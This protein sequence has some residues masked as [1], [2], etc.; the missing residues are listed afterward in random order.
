MI[1]VVVA[2]DE[3]LILLTIADHLIEEGF[4][5]LEARH[6]DEALAMLAH[7]PSIIHVLFTDVWM[8]GG[9]DGIMLTH[10]VKKHW[11][12]IGILV[13]SAHVAPL[14]EHL[15]VGCRFIAKPYNRAHVVHHIRELAKAA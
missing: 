11:P 10:H 5:V 15:P 1:V 6:A 2:E 3:P 12:W 9:M 14:A 4:H 13:T 8:P 7:D